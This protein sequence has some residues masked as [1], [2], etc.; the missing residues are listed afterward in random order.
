MRLVFE[1]FPTPSEIAAG[2]LDFLDTYPEELVQNNTNLYS[3]PV[4]GEGILQ[5]NDLPPF[6]KDINRFKNVIFYANTRTR[7]RL[8]PFQLLGVA[9]IT[10][11]DQITIANQLVSDTYTFVDGISEVTDIQ[12]T[13]TGLAAGEYFSIY[14]A[15]DDNKYYVWY[16]IDGVGTY[17]G[18]TDGTDIKVSFNSTITNTD[19][20]LAQRTRDVLNTL[21]YDFVATSATDTVTVTNIQ[22]GLTANASAETSPFTVTVVTNGNGENAALK[23]VLLSTAPSA[24]QAI[25]ETARSLVRVINKQSTD[26]VNAY[27]ISSETTPPGQI[28]LES[29]N[30]DNIPFYVLASNSATGL[31]FNP[32]LGPI[33]TN[34]TNISVANP[35]VITAAAHGLN[36]LDQIMI[37][38]SDSTPSIN[39]VHTITYIN[40][41]SFSIPVNVTIA[42]SVAVWSKL[43]DLVV[44]DNEIKPNRIYYSKVNQPEAVPILNY[45]DVGPED[46]EILRIFPLR[47][48]L[49]VFKQDGLYRVSGESA[50]FVEGLFDSSCV[51]QAPDSVS[52]T[53]N[54]IYCWSDAGISKVTET[55]TSEI[56]RPI[57]TQILKL[58]SSTFTNFSKITWGIGYDSD[59]S[60]T[61]YTNSATSDDV[62]TIAFRYSN[63][64]NTWTNINRTQ[65]C[66]IINYSDDNLYM[67]SGNKNLIE[68]ERKEFTRKD[69]ADKDFTVQLQPLNLFDDGRVLKF[70]DV[71]EIET[72]DVITQEQS[73]S[74]YDF[75]KLLTQLELDPTVGFNVITS[76]AGAGTT[77]TVTLSSAHNLANSD[78][79]YIKNSNSDPIIDGL[80]QVS[81]VTALTFDIT[82]STPLITQSTLGSS[83]RAYLEMF[84]AKKGDLIRNNLKLLA[85][86]LDTDPGIVGTDYFDRID[87]KSGSINSND[88][89]ISSVVHTS[90]IHELIEGRVVT[91][92]GSSSS[93][94]TIVGT[95]QVFNTGI[96]ASSTT[97]SIPVTVTS[98]GLSGLSYAT[99]QN[100]NSFEDIKACFNDIVTKLNNDSGATYS[101]Y[102]LVTDAKLLESVVLSVNKTLK[103][104]TVNIPLQWVVGPMTVYKSIPC[105]VVY[106]PQIFGDPLMLKQI[107]EATIMFH[108]KAFTKFTASF[109]SDLKPAFTDI[110]FFGQ[111]NGIFGHYSDPGFGYGFFGGASNAAPFRTLIPRDSQRC[112]YLN[113]KI[114][115]A[116][117]R[118]LFSLYGITLTG[119][120]QISTRGYR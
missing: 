101:N 16:E 90:G 33:N 30:L 42:G 102:K 49:F 95:H 9:N 86:K 65:S 38:G 91:I 119:N 64:T 76:T 59:N 1:Q 39:G 3:N 25:D 88:V 35:T 72:G 54:E 99:T 74:I 92:T 36:N 48:S 43:S 55:G 116:V 97:F 23:Q 67:G 107:Y 34:I 51:L 22:S 98:G 53:N 57:D 100:E 45:F 61:I 44:S 4:T 15:T 83:K 73:V 104:V 69:Y 105:E 10:N 120:T 117:A 114:K 50:P 81:N 87:T 75:N 31:S 113:V 68:K 106:S 71:S 28:N 7:H 60:Y 78:Y 80:Y 94:P 2:Q 12:C 5:S 108:S 8:T 19:T 115:H 82:V 6:A 18:P 47:D 17:S 96:F 21:V 26:L 46:K 79:V 85:Q 52:V 58:A 77:I 29:K 63:L 111:G 32:D 112:R 103:R 40:A 27:Y 20:L 14:S 13:L 109:S 110:D 93:N 70:S 84:Q 62:A 89:G 24:A 66:G 11:G 41:N 37:A 118:E 56:S